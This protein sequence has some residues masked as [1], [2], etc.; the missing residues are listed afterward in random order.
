[1]CGVEGRGERGTGCG[2]AVGHAREARR[3][4][5]RGGDDGVGLG[6]LCLTDEE[7][8]Q[9]DHGDAVPEPERLHRRMG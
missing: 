2:S 1:M 5:C 8:G 9:P 3:A 4:G 6:R 7:Q